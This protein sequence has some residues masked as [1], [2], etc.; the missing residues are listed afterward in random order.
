MGIDPAAS[1]D[2]SFVA[3]KAIGPGT[4]VASRF[5]LEDLL[6]DN[7]GAWFWRATDLT[8]ARNVAIHVITADDPRAQA[9]LTA[10]RTS[11]LVSD[12]HILRVL[13]ALQEGDVVHVV[14][15]WGTG[16]SLD[17][18]L[19]ESPLDPRRAAWLVREVAEAITVAHR[20]GV[21]HGR[22]LPENVM[23]T[24]AGSVK[25]IGF[26]VD[27]VLHGRP[28]RLGDGQEPPS[29]HESDVRNLGALLFAALTGRWPGFPV[30]VVPDAP[31][32]Q[33]RVCRPR[34]VRPGVPKALDTLCDQILNHDPRPSGRRF[35]SAAEIAA[36]LADYLGDAVSGAVLP[37]SGPTAFLDP[38]AL[39][40]P[41]TPGTLGSFDGVPGPTAASGTASGAGPTPDPDAT[42]ADL[43]RARARDTALSREPHDT[44]AVPVGTG[45]GGAWAGPR[46]P[47]T[48]MGAGAVP[49]DWGPDRAEDTGTRPAVL[50]SDEKPGSTWIRL[51]TLVAVVC[52]VLLAVVVAYNLGAGG[53][54]EPETPTPGRAPR[55]PRGPPPPGGPRR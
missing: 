30:S 50:A 20:H 7:S 28:S 49:D 5:R 10:A 46:L 32:S 31:L 37:G 35:E 33:D 48:G 44:G 40:P 39:T 17:R 2:G 54:A 18:M 3:H 41:H 19:A 16:V 6:E 15:E 43:L 51:A 1:P 22:L 53:G 25:L 55:V 52:L 29:E 14:H 12:G 47:G 27:A 9:V 24:D 42:Q 21:A 13:D 11:A 4:L 23:V 36:A 26:V 8:L 45:P 34:Q 38:H